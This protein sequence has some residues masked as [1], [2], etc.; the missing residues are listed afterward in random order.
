VRKDDILLTWVAPNWVSAVYINE[1]KLQGFTT[2]NKNFHYRLR[3]SYNNI[4]K[5]VNKYNIYFEKNWNKE[6]IEAITFIYD[7]NDSELKKHENSLLK[8]LYK[9]KII[10]DREKI[11][12]EIKNTPE[13]NKDRLKKLSNLYDNYYYNNNYDKLTLDLYYVATDKNIEKSA[14]F[15]KNSL[16]KIWIYIELHPV[17]VK[18]LLK[19]L[20][21]K[22][23]YDIILAGINLWYFEQN[24]F[25]Y[26]HSSQ[27]DN[28]YNFS[29]TK[30]SLLDSLLEDLKEDLKNKEDENNIKIKI[31]NFITEEQVVK[32]LY[33]PKQKLIVDKNIKISP[34][35]QNIQNINLRTILYDRLYTNEKK[36][37]DLWNKSSLGF[38]KY[39]ID[40]I[41]E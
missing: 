20:N 11:Q 27:V 33:S 40:K 28:W 5:W 21:N 6:L 8:E 13:V 16:E 31:L 12:E 19:I 41:Y 17:S 38:I 25:P 26:F 2:G 39:I 9:A 34:F 29:N 24:I 22:D 35:P 23:E 10:T 36:V 30:K 18:G 4:S 15:M 7:I 32:T 14:F 1:Y 3:E 37:I